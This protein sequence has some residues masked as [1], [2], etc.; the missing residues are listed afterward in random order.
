MSRNLLRYD[1]SF[2]AQQA[3]LRAKSL[4]FLLFSKFFITVCNR[5]EFLGDPYA[6]CAGTYFLT[7]TI[8][9]N[10]PVW[11]KSDGSRHIAFSLANGWTCFNSDLVGRF[12]W[13]LDNTE[14]PWE[15]TWPCNCTMKCV[16]FRGM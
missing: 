3:V 11:S 13:A 14:H 15:G 16:D 10:K 1:Y 4:I 2:L 8:K 6:D 7:S 5:L 12:E 9:N